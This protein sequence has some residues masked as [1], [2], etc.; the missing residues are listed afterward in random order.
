MSHS[1][2]ITWKGYVGSQLDCTYWSCKSF[3]KTKERRRYNTQLNTGVYKYTTSGLRVL[4]SYWNK[5]PETLLS[6]V[7]D[8]RVGEHVTGIVKGSQ[9]RQGIVL[10]PIEQ[11]KVAG[12]E[13]L[14]LY[15]PNPWWVPWKARFQGVSGCP[16][17]ELYWS[18]TP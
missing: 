16:G 10:E 5:P 12:Y 4:E 9:S 8:I 1:Y 6:Q 11:N 13:L 17:T 2:P 18:S 15:K 3:R 14:W 7:L